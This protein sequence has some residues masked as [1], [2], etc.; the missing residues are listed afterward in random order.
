LI[1]PEEFKTWPRHRAPDSR[2]SPVFVVGFPRSGTT[3]L[4]QMLDA[5]PLLQSMDETPFFERLASK[6]R[7]HNPKILADLSVLRQYDVDELRKHYHLMAAERI[8]R[9]WDA[10]L[11]DKNPLNL[12]WLPM[13]Y[14]LFPAAKF[15]FCLRHPCDVILS[16]YMQNFRS[17]VLGA[18]CENL[19]R[20]A[21]AYVQAMQCWLHEA[22]IMKPDVL[23][24]RYEDLVTDFESNTRRIADFLQL[25]DAS[26]MLQFDRRAREKAYIATPSYSQV[27]E[28]INTKGLNRWHLYREYFEP[29]LPILQPMLDHWGYPAR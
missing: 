7:A 5:H 19:P 11:V 12:L 25:E 26:P 9:R 10:Q 1:T 3:L 4:E 6:L 28:P 20:L 27:I 2:E 22:Q 24:S 15:I 13:I 16:C 18:A 21:A 17:S 29:V 8:P 14:R 23:M